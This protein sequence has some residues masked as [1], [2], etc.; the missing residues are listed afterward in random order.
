MWLTR[1]SILRPVTITMVVV[2][3]VVLGLVSRSRLPVDLYP[4]SDIPYVTVVA[5]YA[6]TGPQEVE[7]LI[8]KPIEDAVSTISN[9][10]NVTSTSQ[11]GVGRVAIEF[12]LGTDLDT[13]AN[14][15]R[16]KVDSVRMQLPRDMDP[17]VIEKFSLSSFPV[18]SFAL[19]SP[20][21]PKELRRIADDVIKDRLGKLKGV[22]SV[23][24]VGGDIREILVS[25]DK[26]ALEGYGLTINDVVQALQSTNLNLPSGSIKEGRR[27]YAVRAVGE[28]RSPEELH[29]V[30][31]VT[32]RGNAIYLSDVAETSDTVAERT[33]FARVD[34]V[35]SVAV[36]V[37]K[38]SDANTVEVAD[39]VRNELMALTGQ[40]FDQEGHE[41][42]GVARRPGV[43]PPDITARIT[44]D[45]SAFIREALHDLQK[46]LML[47]SLFA[48][49]VVFLFLHNL[50]GTFIVAL[51]I[52]TS[53]I[54]TFSPMYF[55]GFTLNQMTML[56]LSLTV[57]I[58]V[59]DSIVVIENIYRH[60]RMG[61]VPREAAFSGRT[62]IGLAAITITLVDVVVFV[63]IA[64]M[65]GIVGQFFRQFGLT[66]A[67]ATLFS[68]FVSF[69]LTPMLSSRWFREA[70]ALPDEEG[71]SARQAGASIF[72][73]AV[74]AFFAAFDR[75]YA[76]F[77]TRYRGVLSWALDHRLV[78][79]FIGISALMASVAVAIP[80][81]SKTVPLALIGVLTIV[82]VLAGGKG[83]RLAMAVIGAAC[84]LLGGTAYKKLG[85]EMFP[86]VD[87][88]QVT[89][90]V[91]L[92]AGSSLAATD[93]VV[94]KLEGFLL[95]R[96]GNPEVESVLSTVGSDGASKASVAVT[97]IDKTLRKRCDSQFA[98]AVGRYASAIPG[99][100]IKASV[101]AHLGGPGQSPVSIELSGSNMDELVRV[102]DRIKDRVA[103][104]PG[105][106]NA[107][108]TWKVG[109]PE[110]RAV[111]DRNRAADRGITT[112]QVASALRA[113]LEG[114]TT[115]K[116]REGSNQYDIRVRL[117]QADRQSV[118][119]VADLVV[120]F[121]SGP[122]YLGDIA[123]VSLVTGP[124]KID[125][126]NRQRMVAV[127][128]DIATGYTA[129]NVE[130]AIARAIKDVPL[131]NVS[132][133]FGGE[134]E[135]RQESFG[136]LDQSLGLSV[137]LIYVLQ[138]ALF[139]GYLS[140]FIIMFA[141]PMA[142]VGAL[143]A[144]VITGKS[145]SIISM[146]GI[147]MLMGLVGKNAILL[148][149][150]TNTLRG[151]GMERREALLEAAPIRLRPILM[152]TLA[153]VCGMLP[154]A[155]ATARGGE[156][157]APMAI[158]VIGGLIVSTL[159]T[160]LVIPVLYTVFDGVAAT[161]TRLMRRVLARV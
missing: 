143:L 12:N 34:G 49:L 131:G 8:T 29:D 25:V 107:D 124:T 67:M 141:L 58:L 57:G 104:V 102:A 15:V 65:G 151:Q 100:N 132:M 118:A 46:H 6:G 43:L 26:D 80:A 85:R 22:G 16:E 76:A 84:L 38:Q 56:G 103:R 140:P 11:E 139:E 134:S 150:Y 90:S 50:R 152:T 7:T 40:T 37:L 64:F 94:R 135:I 160:L 113:S 96:K 86:Q 108:T 39:G 120:G 74:A 158:T 78:T 52:P 13:A 105:I 17:P 36:T 3:I 95:D 144:I 121:G 125:R 54:A 101:Y 130:Q 30:R 128:A 4:K 63:P 145:L 155:L 35:D 68:L 77:R 42:K 127:T 91:E 133:K 27:E 136:H 149:D 31:L 75:I 123:Q 28:F 51:A 72:S 20:R 82:G 60:L 23:S 161:F 62:E 2:A 79:V 110:L 59:D 88:G 106:L 112:Y 53:I 137:V 117:N 69:T 147:I 81:Q 99:A 146:I 157:R 126:K 61:E 21:P 47:G 98:E 5:T 114:D 73:R 122:V 89:V 111:I 19:A 9:V 70:E 45:Q 1:V 109:K 10:K 93:E 83:G 48:V 159:L 32:R 142:L 24:V 154:I 92:P 18:V 129:G 87:Q 119:Q 138:A 44:R 116:Y 153:M 41:V 66:V 148:V 71:R 55:S 156:V 33:S 97:L 115:S 14:D